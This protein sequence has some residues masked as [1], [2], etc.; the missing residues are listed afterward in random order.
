MASFVALLRAVNV[1]GTGKLAMSDLK[2][3]CEAAGCVHVRTYIAS[4]NVVFASDGTEQSI[5]ALL[6]ARLETHTGHP[7]CVLVRTATAI[8]DIV[9]RNPFPCASGDRVAVIFL[10][11]AAASDIL[12]D[13]SGR[14]DDEKLLLGH[15]EIYVHYAGGIGR[16]KLR[17]PAARTG[18]AR[19]MNTVTK[20]S[21]MADTGPVPTASDPSTT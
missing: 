7:V 2:A 9:A 11:H 10:E 16:S 20:L 1:G 3:V 8:A 12:D 13:V 19:N 5:K 18:T 15:R 21:V 6:E 14:A 4:G 17:I